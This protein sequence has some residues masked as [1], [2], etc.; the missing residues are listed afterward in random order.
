[1][2]GGPLSTGRKI[3]VGLF[4]GGIIAGSVA[5]AQTQAPYEIEGRK[6]GYLFMTPATRSLQDDEFQNPGMFI[7]ERGRELWNRPE[8]PDRKSCASCHGDAEA[9][10]AG[11]ATRYPVFDSTANGLINLEMRINR[12]RGDHMKAAP[13]KYESEELLAL[14]TYISMQSRGQP[15]NVAIDGPAKPFFDQG[16]AFYDTRR[17]QLDLSCGQCHDDRV[18][19]RLRGD[20]I[21]QGQLNGFPIH[22]LSWRSMLSRHRI[23]AWCNTTVRAEPYEAG[24]PEYLALELYVAWRGRGLPIEAPAVRR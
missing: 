8:G 1:M 19:M 13:L 9:S 15:M 3:L 22:R 23:F 4:A 5:I 7:V 21:S 12:E 2:R 20:V 17:G 10:M 18:G 16:K 11:V 6:S 24:S 14:T